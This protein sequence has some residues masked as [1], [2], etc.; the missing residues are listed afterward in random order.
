MRVRARTKERIHVHAE[1][2]WAVARPLLRFAQGKQNLRTRSSVVSRF[3]SDR[4]VVDEIYESSER[5]W[6]TKEK[7][8]ADS[9]DV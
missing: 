7:H 6:N 4:E 5:R 1:R 9:D 2:R 8:E 3:T